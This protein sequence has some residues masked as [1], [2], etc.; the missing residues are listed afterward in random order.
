MSDGRHQDDKRWLHSFANEVLAVCPSC[1]G[2]VRVVEREGARRAVCPACA[3]TREDNPRTSTWG[4]PYDPYFGLPLWL[5]APCAGEVL[6]AFNGEHLDVLESYVAAGL[7]ERPPGDARPQSM[8]ERLP[9]WAK[10]AKNRDG[11]LAAIARL[12][13]RLAAA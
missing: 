9:V 4:V 12:R 2:C 6:W 11:V 13:A 8:L 7:R 1:D 3:W 10:A 5:Q